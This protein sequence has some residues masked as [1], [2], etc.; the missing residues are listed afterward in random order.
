MLHAVPDGEGGLV[1]VGQLQERSTATD[2]WSQVRGV[3]FRLAP[4]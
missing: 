3:V 2:E 4:T 1:G